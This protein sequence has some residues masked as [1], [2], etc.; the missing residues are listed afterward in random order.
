MPKKLNTTPMWQKEK[1]KRRSL[2]KAL[3]NTFAFWLTPTSAQEK[4]MEHRLKYQNLNPYS[5]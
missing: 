1:A 2:I 4:I 5:F 3:L